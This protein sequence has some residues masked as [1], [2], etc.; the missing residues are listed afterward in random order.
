MDEEEDDS[1]IPLTPTATAEE[2]SSSAADDNGTVPEPHTRG[3]ITNM[4]TSAAGRS[5]SSR[6]RSSAGTSTSNRTAHQQ[7][8]D[9]R[10]LQQRLEAR[11]R[12]KSNLVDHPIDL[13][14]KRYLVNL[15]QEV[16]ALEWHIRLGLCMLIL[17]ITT[18]VFLLSTWYFWYPRFVLVTMILVAATLYLDVFGFQQRFDNLGKLLVS[19]ETVLQLIQQLDSTG[20]RRLAVVLLL[21][22]TGLEMRTLSF[23]SGIK[24]ETGW[25]LYN[26]LLSSSLLGLMMY[27]FRVQ[28]IKPRECLYRGLLLL[29]GSALWVTIYTTNL[30]RLPILAAPFLTATGTIMITY[31]DDDMEWVS[32]VLRH[33]LRLALRDVLS[34]MGEKVTED[35]ML[36]LAILRW[37]ADYWASAPTTSAPDSSSSSSE[38]PAAHQSAPS[39]T[40]GTAASAAGSAGSTSSS[41]SATGRASGSS[42]PTPLPQTSSFTGSQRRSASAIFQRRHD[43]SW[44]ELLPML[45]VATEHMTSEVQMLQSN[46]QTMGAVPNFGTPPRRTTEPSTG[47]IDS[48]HDMLRALNVD[49]R[50]EPAV[51]AYKRAVESFP[52]SQQMAV[53][54]SILRRCP[55]FL[56]I[57]FHIVMVK[58]GVLSSTMVL[59][60]FVVMEYHRIMAWL[61]C[62]EQV[63]VYF[64]TVEEPEGSTSDNSRKFIPSALRDADPM[65]ILL[66]GDSYNPL[67]PPA[68]LLVWRNVA[69]SVSALEVGLTAARCAETTAVAV[70][71]AG[72]VM[73][74]VQFGQEIH[75][76]GLLHG[77]LVMGK[78][79]ILMHTM[80]E[81]VRDRESTKYTH[82]VMGAM[83]NA[84]RVAR[85][86]QTLAH[87]DKIGHVIQPVV[88]AACSLS[89]Y[90]WLWGRETPPDASSSS[91]EEM[92]NDRA[93]SVPQ[94]SWATEKKSMDETPEDQSSS[95]ATSPDIAQTG[96]IPEGLDQ[97]SDLMEEIVETYG[98]GQVNEVRFLSRPLFGLKSAV[99]LFSHSLCKN[100]LK[101][102][103]CANG[104]R[105]S[106]VPIPRPYVTSRRRWQ[107]L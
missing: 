102:T 101:R 7:Q 52:P 83:E 23:L 71:F 26:L 91:S 73:S 98:D 85:N 25:S 8:Q 59:L 76:H 103:N 31:Q 1:W 77:L 5:Q 104:C 34:S 17:G 80:D 100:R 65:V 63:K 21:I 79:A 45:N 30:S 9:T 47:P 15:A 16:W 2:S 106:Q 58:P 60:P 35:E 33:A 18:K 22:P 72:N 49:E 20:I 29:Y 10:N 62:C 40:S 24:A 61:H 64:D 90:G 57:L 53:L 95:G 88:W 82:A 54:L 6:G 55:A 67:R 84:Q 78:E 93:T 43:V 68:L 38:R 97:L 107:N 74:L 92:T 89:G 41:G 27:W 39:R 75:E 105:M 4:H 46:P 69:N 19:P 42:T 48:F 12:L 70:Q 94:E 28:H 13:F 11:I 32:R 96:T 86:V 3:S 44:E 50:A 87:D 51:R 37:I 66:V 81:S 36:Q 14:W 99:L 56:T